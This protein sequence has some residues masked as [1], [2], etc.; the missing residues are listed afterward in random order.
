MSTEENKALVR[1]YIEVVWNQRNLAALDELL[2]PNCQ[3]YVSVCSC[4]LP[5]FG[6]NLSPQHHHAR[7]EWREIGQPTRRKKLLKR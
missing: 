7:T 3:R 1:R 6:H 2:A 5:P 4:S